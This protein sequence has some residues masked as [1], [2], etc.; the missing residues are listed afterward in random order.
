MKT[1]GNLMEPELPELGV[2]REF[3]T[4]LLVRFSW[5]RHIDRRIW[6]GLDF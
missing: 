3:P 4:L 6:H 1:Q 2:C 5:G